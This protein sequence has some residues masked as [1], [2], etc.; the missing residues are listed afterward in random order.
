MLR[1][2]VELVPAGDESRKR[3][4]AC[5]ILGNVTN[6]DPVSDYQIRA[7]EGDNPVAGTKEWDSRGMIAGHD[8][9]STVWALV[10]R[11]ARWAAA[12]AEKQ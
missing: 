9:R 3:E 2:R 5:A 4:L 7:R 1:I 11:A 8:R 10:E 6:L 12:E